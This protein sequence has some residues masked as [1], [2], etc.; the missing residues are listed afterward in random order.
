MSFLTKQQIMILGKSKTTEKCMC[1]LRWR[2]TEPVLIK[3][4]RQ[5]Y[6]KSTINI[7]ERSF[8]C[9]AFI[10]VKS[11]KTHFSKVGFRAFCDGWTLMLKEDPTKIPFML[12]SRVC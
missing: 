8:R 6:A 2:V 1:D 4:S 7:V 5:T 9:V 12:G 11:C 3:V 10:C